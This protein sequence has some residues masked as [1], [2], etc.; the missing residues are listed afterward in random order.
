MGFSPENAMTEPGT[1]LLITQI[2]AGSIGQRWPLV[3]MKLRTD[4]TMHLGPV[5]SET[6]LNDCAP[7]LALAMI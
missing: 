1:N 2:G 7:C 4:N 6:A 3:R 5:Q